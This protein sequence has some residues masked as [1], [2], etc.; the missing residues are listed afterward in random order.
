MQPAVSVAGAGQ[1]HRFFG[2]KVRRLRM[3]IRYSFP[4]PPQGPRSEVR[5]PVS[6]IT[7][8]I[9]GGIGPLARVEDL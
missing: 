1:L 2:A 6:V 4:K 7:L 8:V 9:Y 3:T 5:H